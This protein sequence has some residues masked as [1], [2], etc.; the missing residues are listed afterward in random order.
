V[1]A[2]AS[3]GASTPR[4]PAALAVS[5]ARVTLLGSASRTIEIRNR[6]SEPAVVDATTA[7]YALGLRGRPRIVPGSR[8]ARGA[9]SWLT[10]RPRRLTVPSGGRA[11]LVVTSATP[12]RAGAGDHDALVLLSTRAAANGHVAVLMRLGVVVDVR[13]AGAI[14]RHVELRGL[15]VRA[16]GRVRLLELDL[17]NRGNVVE[18]LQHGRVTATLRHG[19]RVVAK[20]AAEPRELLPGTR[21]LAEL[22][23][24]GDVRGP[25]TARV[26]VGPAGPGGSVWRRS[27]RIRL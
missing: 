10:L 24:R 14:V 23:Y 5:P 9:A 1:L 4:P 12:A 27:F 21:G 11:S 22:R 20:L 6:G 2:P 25:V 15:R 13:V 7:G 26:V 16:G 19:G 3:A 8:A 17:A 18:T